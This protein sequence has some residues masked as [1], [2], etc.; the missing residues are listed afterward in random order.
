ML[1]VIYHSVFFEHLL[2]SNF[3]R[4][5]SYSHWYLKIVP[6]DLIRPTIVL[7]WEDEPVAF[8]GDLV[9]RFGPFC[10][11]FPPT[12]VLFLILDLSILFGLPSLLSYLLSLSYQDLVQAE[13]NLKWVRL[14]S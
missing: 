7:G 8:K 6:P 9:L 11:I 10:R 1:L 5:K 2:K 3:L 4:L 14:R 13:C 12:V